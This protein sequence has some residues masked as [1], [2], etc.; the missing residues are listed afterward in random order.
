VVNEFTSISSKFGNK[1]LTTISECGSF[2]DPDNLVKDAAMWSWYMVWPGDFVRSATYNPLDLWKKAFNHSYVLTL[3]EMP[4]IKTCSVQPKDCY[5]VA[6]GTASNDPCGVCVG[7]TTGRNTCKT[8]VNGNYIIKPVFSGLCVETGTNVLQQTCSGTNGQVWMVA[9]SGNFYQIKNANTG[10][11]LS[12]STSTAGTSLTTSSSTSSLWRLEDAG[13]GAYTLVP[14]TN[15]DLVIDV[16]GGNTSAGTNL[17]LWSRTGSDNQKFTFTGTVVTDLSEGEWENGIKCYPNPSTHEF[18]LETSG[19]FAYAIYDLSGE[20]LEKGNAQNAIS[21]GK[22]QV[23]GVYI[24]KI[25]TT[26][27]TKSIKA[28]KF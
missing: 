22:N 6:G 1:K 14:S 7:G 23:P 11:Y 10:Q 4:N 26:L 8:L 3:D 27:G 21:V 5:G 2:P 17:L 15:Y 16:S 12:Y 20:E 24:I 28:S 19:Q 9:K 18:H 13:N 25:Q